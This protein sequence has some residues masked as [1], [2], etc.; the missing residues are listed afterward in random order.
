MSLA[1]HAIAWDS[2]SFSLIC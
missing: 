1:V 2:A